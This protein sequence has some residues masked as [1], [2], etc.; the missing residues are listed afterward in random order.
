MFLTLLKQQVH[1]PFTFVAA[2]TLQNFSVGHIETRA[3]WSAET[4]ASSSLKSLRF[5]PS[6]WSQT[7]T[8]RPQVRPHCFWAPAERK[9][10]SCVGFWVACVCFRRLTVWLL[11]KEGGMNLIS[12]RCHTN[13]HVF[14]TLG[15]LLP[16]T[17]TS[18]PRA[19]LLCAPSPRVWPSALEGHIWCAQVST[20]WWIQTERSSYTFLLPTI[21]SPRCEWIKIL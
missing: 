1:E 4:A 15:R 13:S 6:P 21:S 18:P 14:H 12:P 8:M 10:G 20:V 3:R 19:N 7:H 16:L 5:S 9:P 11:N 2:Q 17:L